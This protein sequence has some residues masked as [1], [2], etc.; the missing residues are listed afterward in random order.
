MSIPDSSISQTC[1][2]LL[3][4]VSVF[5]QKVEDLKCDTLPLQPLLSPPD[6]Q[7]I[8]F[9]GL[10]YFRLGKLVKGRSTGEQ[11]QSFLWFGSCV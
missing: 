4:W 5:P 1:R 3:C 8:P 11:E 6:L 2:V 7:A 10:P 9:V